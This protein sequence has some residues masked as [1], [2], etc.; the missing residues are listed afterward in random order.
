MTTVPTHICIRNDSPGKV[1]FILPGQ[2]KGSRHRFRDITR[3]TKSLSNHML[4]G[5]L[6][7]SLR[8]LPR[9][10]IPRLL[11]DRL[12][13]THPLPHRPTH[14]H[15]RIRRPQNIRMRMRT[16]HMLLHHRPQPPQRQFLTR[17]H[18]GR[19]MR[20]PPNMLIPNPTLLQR[21]A[22]RIPRKKSPV[23]LLHIRVPMPTRSQHEI[24]IMLQPAFG[25]IPTMGANPTVQFPC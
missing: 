19:H 2:I 23:T 6:H 14:P 1:I 7:P 3:R 11:R 12:P 20:Q 4:I 10:P 17:R 25:R 22:L 13:H 9:N 16:P 24:R 15:E 21:F 8:L 18:Q 5:L